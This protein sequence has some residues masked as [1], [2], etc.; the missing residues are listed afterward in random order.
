[1][2]RGDFN[3]ENSS[4]LCHFSHI[5]NSSITHLSVQTHN[6]FIINENLSDKSTYYTSRNHVRFILANLPPEITC[7][8]IKRY[9]R[10]HYK[11]AG[12]LF[13]EMQRIYDNSF[14]E[15]VC[16][17]EYLQRIC[18]IFDKMRDKFDNFQ[19]I[20]ISEK[21][22]MDL[23]KQFP[24]I[25]QYEIQRMK[26]APITLFYNLKM[27]K[28]RIKWNS[29]SYLYCDSVKYLLNGKYS[30]YN[31][32]RSI[33]FINMQFER[34]C[35]IDDLFSHI[36]EYEDAITMQQFQL[37]LG[38]L[39]FLWMF[40]TMPL[41]FAS[42]TSNIDHSFPIFVK[43]MNRKT[44]CCVV[45][46]DSTVMGETVKVLPLDW[47][48]GDF[49]VFLNGTL[50]VKDAGLNLNDFINIQYKS[51][52]GNPETC[53]VLES[54]PANELDPIQ[55]RYNLRDRSKIK[56]RNQANQT[57]LQPITENQ[58]IPLVQSGDIRI[59]Y[60]NLDGL[61]SKNDAVGPLMNLLMT[62]IIFI[63][64]TKMGAHKFAPFPIVFHTNTVNGN[65]GMACGLH[66]K[67]KNRQLNIVASSP[68]FIKVKF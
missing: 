68:Y 11:S 14:V 13:C 12:H 65:F 60:L 28:K 53:T 36:E 22:W 67:Y 8:S 29:V 52:G 35:R 3:E 16:K 41:V 37:H 58:S 49:K 48:I 47:Q 40:L 17:R 56:S 63:A 57:S 4:R 46:S 42:I 34:N 55:S 27:S 44:Q 61:Q 23:I 50:C 64:E 26:S 18:H 39:V 1:M 25:L 31:M 51:R 15:I 54:I 45:G 5:I 21:Y 10:G 66:P 2:T 32:K 20:G 24:L 7:H 62:D 43:F 19:A 6:S 9:I 33:I 59:S 30:T 38:L